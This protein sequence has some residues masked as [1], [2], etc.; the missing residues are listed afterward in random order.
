M[1]SLQEEVFRTDR[2]ATGD[3]STTDLSIL[4]ISNGHISARGR[5]IY[6]MFG[7]RMGFSGSV[8]RMTLF[9]VK[10][11]SVSMWEKTMREE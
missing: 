9:R 1:R 5:P 6:F 7:S 3:R 2:P 8:D 11:N 4:K 10:P